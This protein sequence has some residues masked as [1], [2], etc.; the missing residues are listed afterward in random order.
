[1]RKPPQDYRGVGQFVG[2]SNETLR[3]D[4]GAQAADTSDR[5]RTVRLC[6]GTLTLTLPPEAGLLT[7]TALTVINDGAGT[8]TIRRANGDLMAVLATPDQSR[9]LLWTGQ[10]WRIV[11]AYL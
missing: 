5:V 1:M 10:A 8:V 6:V 7:A 4:A 11:A 3:A 9:T 2:L